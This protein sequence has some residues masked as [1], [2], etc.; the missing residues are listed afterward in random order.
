MT[1]EPTTSG[2]SAQQRRFG[3]VV[4]ALVNALL[5]YLVN[6]WPG[7]QAVPFLTDGVNDVL[8]VVNLS[9][10]AGVVVNLVYLV[11]D[12]AWVTA[13]GQVVLSAI[14]LAVAIRLLQVFPFDFSAYAVDWELVTRVVLG[15]AVFGSAVGV[16][17]SVVRLVR[18]VVTRA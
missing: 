17:A 3:Y 8:A 11:Y 13:A 12:P 5:L 6:V 18:A 14:A 15:F 2:R 7:W 9:L 10:T 4:A 16:V 1:T